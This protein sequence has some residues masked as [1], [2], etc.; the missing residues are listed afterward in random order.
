MQHWFQKEIF[1]LQKKNSKVDFYLQKQKQVLKKQTKK[2]ILL[3]LL[4]LFCHFQAAP[5]RFEVWWKSENWSEITGKLA[6]LISRFS[7]LCF[8]FEEK[9]LCSILCFLAETVNSMAE[10]NFNARG[11]GCWCCFSLLDFSFCSEQFFNHLNDFL[12]CLH[13]SALTCALHV[14]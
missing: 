10:Q 9:Q 6:H 4:L 3:F 5:S 11:L 13:N 14:D 1:Q 8:A 7:C 12:L 2:K